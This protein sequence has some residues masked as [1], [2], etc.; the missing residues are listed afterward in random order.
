MAQ[1]LYLSPITLIVQYLTNI[2]VLAAGGQVSTYVAGTVNTPATTYTDSTGLVANPN[3]MT[4]NAAGRPAAASG[5]PV[6]FW[7]LPGVVLKISVTDAQG[8]QLVGPLD[9]IS[10]INDLTNVSNSLATLLAS[11]AS[12]NLAGVGPVAGADLVANAVKSYDVFADLRA[13]NVPAL[14]AG[15]TLSVDVQSGTVIG[16]GQGGT[17]YW[18]STSVTADNALTVIK[19]N[20]LTNAQ[21]G[22]YIRRTEPYPSIFGTPSSGTF[23]VGVPLYIPKTADQQVANTMTLTNDTQLTTFLNNNPSGAPVYYWVQLRLMLLGIGGTG[24][25]YQLRLTFGGSTLSVTPG[26]WNVSSNGSFSGGQVNQVLNSS[27]VVAAI[28]STAGDVATLDQVIVVNGGGQ[29]TLQFTQA[30]NSANAT[31]MKQG[32]ILVVTRLG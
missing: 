23:P 17:F 5:A 11:P 25:G 27:V 7:T 22:R 16:D 26:S 24:Q 9:N 31:V 3:P 18:S 20:G 6:A 21:P 8:N 28:S 10:A 19:P 32:S 2:G 30:A 29:L 15:Q 12:S 13:A 14:A 4:L 1:T